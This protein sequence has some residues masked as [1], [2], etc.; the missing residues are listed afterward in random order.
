MH[1]LY[2]V[3]HNKTKIT[4]VKLKSGLLAEEFFLIVGRGKG[5]SDMLLF[6]VS[7]ICLKDKFEL[8]RINSKQRKICCQETKLSSSS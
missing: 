3:K 8:G 7:K 6:W 1:N 5:N 4:S 2:Y